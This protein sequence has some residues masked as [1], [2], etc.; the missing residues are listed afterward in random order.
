MRKTSSKSQLLFRQHVAKCGKQCLDLSLPNKEAA[1]QFCVKVLDLQDLKAVNMMGENES[2]L[3][4]N[5][6]IV[7]Q[8]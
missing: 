2:N 8:D 7:L 4:D 1:W 3:P 5:G 6:A